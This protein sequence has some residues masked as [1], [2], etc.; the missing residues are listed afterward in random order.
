MAQ[1][2]IPEGHR[3]I[4]FCSVIQRIVRINWSAGRPL[5]A[6]P[7][8]QLVATIEAVT[9]DGK[10]YLAQREL[11]ADDYARPVHELSFD[12]GE[13]APSTSP[14]EVRVWTSGAVPLTLSSITVER[15]AAPA[16]L[17][18]TA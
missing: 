7:R 14:I 17:A 6:V 12:L 10:T 18:S 1:N 3:T 16:R 2:N 8:D 11:W 15:I 5:R 4:N 13:R 9:G